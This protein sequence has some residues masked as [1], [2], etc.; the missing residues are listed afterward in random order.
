MLELEED[1]K[2]LLEIGP[3]SYFLIWP[4]F[5]SLFLS[6]LLLGFTLAKAGFSFWF[7]VSFLISAGIFWT[8]ALLAYARFYQNRIFLTNKR[9]WAKKQLKPFKIEIR[10]IK[11]EDILEISCRI[12]GFKA[13][14][15]GFGDLIIK[16]R[17]GKLVIK[18]VAKPDA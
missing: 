8:Y 12:E 9:L 16:T 2:I 15:L 11:L 6:F 1:E 18:N 14:A 5:W 3:H 10:E 4:I 13:I 17:A 7:F